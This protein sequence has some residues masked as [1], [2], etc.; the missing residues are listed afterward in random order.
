[1]WTW[2]SDENEDFA[3]SGPRRRVRSKVYGCIEAKVPIFASEQSDFPYILLYDDPDIKIAK[4]KYP[5]IADK[6]A[7]GQVCLDENAYER[8]ARLGIIQGAQGSRY[9]FRIGDSIAH[10][11]TR[12]HAWLRLSAFQDMKDPF[13]GEPETVTDP[14]DERERQ[15]NVKEK[16]AQLFP[17]GVHACVVGDQFAEAW[18]QSMDDCIDVAHAFI[19]KGQSRMPIMKS[20]VVVQDRFNS[21]MNYVAE[22]NDYCV[23]STWVGCDAQ[24]YAAIKKQKAAPGSYRNLKNLPPGAKMSDQLFQ[25]KGSDIP[26]SFQNYIEFLYGALPQFQLA[27]PPSIWGQAMSDQKTASGYQL[28]AQQAMGILS[29]FWTVETKMLARMYYH[30]CLAIKNDADYPE[31]IT[32]A[33]DG[34]RNTIVR[35]ASLSKGNFRAY[36]DTESGFPETTAAKRNT[37]NA[38]VAQLAQTPLGPQIFASPDNVAFYLRENGLPELVIPEAEARNKQLREIET[39]LSQSPILAPPLVMMLQEG[40]GIPAIMDAIKGAAQ[41]MEQQQQIAHA[42]SVIVAQAESEP[43]PPPPMPIDPATIARSSVPV[44]ESDYHIWEAK[45]CQD[46]LSSDERHTEETIGRPSAAP[47]DMGQPRPNMAGILN[48]M[49]HWLEHLA[50]PQMGM[51]LVTPGPMAAAPGATLPADNVAPKPIAAPNAEPAVIQ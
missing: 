42:A 32:I 11:I 23:P 9:G 5:W 48:V 19:G 26:A 29:S 16:L 25:E 4:D 28:A 41:Q 12:A 24:E 37:L 2:M 43:V 49:L 39:L 40:A 1:M 13:E 8:V 15:I 50:A 46:W 6:L 7:A 33:G 27:V 35:K 3:N 44:W 17:A 47:E 14:E 36:P 31:E 51:P 30:N 10:L 34:G 20:M 21:S 38:M 18:N 45:K 22:T